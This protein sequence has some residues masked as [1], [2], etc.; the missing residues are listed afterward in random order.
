MKT[1]LALVVLQLLLSGLAIGA[2][3][4]FKCTTAEG[5][6]AADLV[7]DLDDRTMLWA[8]VQKYVIHAVDDRYISAYLTPRQTEVGG[9]VWVLNRTNGDYVRATI[10]VTWPTPESVG[11][12]P[13]TLTA[14]TYRGRCSRPIL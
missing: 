5:Y 13:G 11:K 14:S 2:P 7:V 6:P 8:T 1:M 9:E 3:V 10:G 12:G 4:T